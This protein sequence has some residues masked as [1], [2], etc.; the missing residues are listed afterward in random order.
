MKIEDIKDNYCKI[1]KTS[2]TVKNPKNNKTV[3]IVT[4]ITTRETASNSLIFEWWQK[5]KLTLGAENIKNI[6]RI[7]NKDYYV[8]NNMQLQFVEKYLLENNESGFY[9]SDIKHY[10][11]KLI[12]AQKAEDLGLKVLWLNL[13]S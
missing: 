5:Y 7:N 9:N 13:I 8:L 3:G 2:I 1:C 6:I 10:R 12:T 4:D 11:D